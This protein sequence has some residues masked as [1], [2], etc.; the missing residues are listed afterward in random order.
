MRPLD[1]RAET[2]LASRWKKGAILTTNWKLQPLDEGEGT[3]LASREGG[4]EQFCPPNWKLRPLD[5]EKKQFWPPRR[6]GGSGSVLQLDFRPLYEEQEQF[7]PPGEEGVIS[8][9][10]KLGSL[11]EGEET[12][13]ASRW[14]K[15]AALSSNWEDVAASTGAAGLAKLSLRDRRVLEDDLQEKMANLSISWRKDCGTFL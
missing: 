8:F 4:M 14:G 3:V 15:V 9:N 7:W 1:E 6:G 10:W 13:L 11:D 2:F 12:V 5:K